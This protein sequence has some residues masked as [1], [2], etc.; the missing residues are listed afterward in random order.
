MHPARPGAAK[1]SVKSAHSQSAAMV[2]NRIMRFMRQMHSESDDSALIEAAINRAWLDGDGAP[3]PAGERLVR[4][5]N[6][7][8]RFSA[9]SS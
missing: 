6:D 3:T 5:F 9:Y 7:L 1:R 2:R 4:A 8:D